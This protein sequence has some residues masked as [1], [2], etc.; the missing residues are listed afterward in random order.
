MIQTILIAIPGL[1]ALIVCIRRGPEQALLDV[2]LPVLLL[3]PEY[4]WPISGQLSFTDTTILPIATFLLFRSKLKWQWNTTDFLV[5]AYIA[6]T[7]VAEGMNKG[8]KPG[9]KILLS[10]S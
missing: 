4:H 7:V 9:A 2:Y 1:V 10:R 6:V 5:I 8:Y 3:L